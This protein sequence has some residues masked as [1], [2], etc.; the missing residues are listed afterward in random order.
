MAILL[1]GKI[2]KLRQKE[3]PIFIYFLKSLGKG[4]SFLIPIV[5]CIFC[6]FLN[7]DL[8]F[9]L[10][11]TRVFWFGFALFSK[12]MKLSSSHNFQEHSTLWALLLRIKKN[13]RFCQKRR[14][15]RRHSSRLRKDGD[16]FLKE[17][18]Y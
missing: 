3:V 18:Y 4:R 5:M 11:I 14:G 15:V 13:I 12:C 9:C 10:F 17:E 1:G 6:L 7:E 16:P 8:V 2:G